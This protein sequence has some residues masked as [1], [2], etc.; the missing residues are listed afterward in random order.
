MTLI[1]AAKPFS[2]TAQNTYQGDSFYPVLARY[3]G[4]VRRGN[5]AACFIIHILVKPLEAADQV[6]A[7]EPDL[8]KSK[9]T[10]YLLDDQG[11]LLD[12]SRCDFD[13][14]AKPRLGLRDVRALNEIR[15]IGGS[16]IYEAT[17][18]V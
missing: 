4:S 11:F 18:S 12:S 17:D 10:A 16:I 9:A 7:I 8:W 14:Q 3:S 1:P 13:L 2:P 6:A 15:D 5:N